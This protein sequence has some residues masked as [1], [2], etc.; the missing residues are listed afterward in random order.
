M[1]FRDWNF[2]IAL[3][4]LS[5]LI[6]SQ[7]PPLRVLLR[8]TRLIMQ[9]YDRLNVTHTLGNPNVNL[10]V[11]LLND[12]GRAVRIRSLALE[13]SADD[14][15]KLSLS[16]QTFTRADGT[17]GTFLFIPFRLEPDKDWANVVAFFTPFNMTDERAASKLIK[18]LR[19]DVDLKLTNRSQEARDRKDLAEADPACV[20][21]AQ[22]FF[23]SHNKWRPGEY[24]AALKVHC[25]P[26]SASQICKFRFT[27]FEADV[28]EFEDRASRF[29]YGAGVYYKDPENI[30]VSPRIKNL[31]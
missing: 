14:S 5:A 16:A 8:R 20:A 19:A 26:E 28:Q 18:E 9:P 10:H 17:P 30:E 4:A 22:E 6:L 2:W 12:G 15:T 21:K 24:N 3:V 29:K 11:Q 23:R 13:I 7:L 25:T 31:E 1:S 27:L